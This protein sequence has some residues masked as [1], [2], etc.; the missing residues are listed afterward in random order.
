MRG[1]WVFITLLGLVAV[2]GCGREGYEKRQAKTLNQLEYTRRLQKNLMEAPNEK[3]FT[4]LAIYIRPPKEQ[5][6]AKTGQL[7]VGEGQFDLDASFNDKTESVLHVLARVKRP[8]KP[9]T[10]GEAPPPPPAARG[11]FVA[12]VL[13]VLTSVFGSPEGLQTPKFSEESKKGNRFRRLIFTADNKEVKVY[14]YKLD[15]SEVALIFVYDPA[16]RGALSS[17]IDLCLESFA[18]GAKATRLYNGGDAAEED[19]EAGAPVPL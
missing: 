12:D 9:P 2:P 19:A 3:K 13:G 11:E 10:K 16:L 14:T 18:T 5:A 8:K 1:V 7:P 17:K 15:N 4:D 6:L